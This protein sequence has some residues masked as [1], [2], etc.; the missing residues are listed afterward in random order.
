MKKNY[1]EVFNFKA[2]NFGKSNTKLVF[3]DRIHITLVV[4]K[5]F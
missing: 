5:F 1:T 2:C 3:C 4:Q